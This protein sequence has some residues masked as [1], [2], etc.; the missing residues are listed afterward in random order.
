LHLPNGQVAWSAWKENAMSKQ[1]RMAH[2]VK[3]L[4]DGKTAVAEVLFY[5]NMMLHNKEKTLALISEFS[6]PHTNLFENLF[7][8]VFACHYQ[9]DASL[10][11]VEVHT[12]V[13]HHH[14]RH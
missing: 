14:L 7:Q 3:L 8:M 6:Q 1:P 11:L 2:N 5:F 13:M 4:V 9:G 12:T 10:K